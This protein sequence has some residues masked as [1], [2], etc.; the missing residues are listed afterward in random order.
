MKS[1]A[2]VIAR[3]GARR[4]FRPEAYSL[5]LRRANPP[6]PRNRY[7]A[8]SG[9]QVQRWRQSRERRCWPWPRR[10][11]NAD[12]APSE[13]RRTSTADTFVGQR[14][15]V[16]PFDRGASHGT[17]RWRGGDQAQ[18][19]TATGLLEAEKKFRPVKRL[20]RA[21]RFT[22]PDESTVVDSTGLDRVTCR[23]SRAA[24]INYAVDNFLA[25]RLLAQM[26]PR[27]R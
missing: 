22:S 10:Q 4:V 3:G 14:H 26:G 23:K 17:R 16:V 24:A 5:I 13:L 19:W 7:P 27:D 11:R 9:C 8:E 15:R 2:R 20:P 21:G 12:G 1:P 25:R 6:R 18:R